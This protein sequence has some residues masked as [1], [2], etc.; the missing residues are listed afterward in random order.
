[1]RLTMYIWFPDKNPQ[2]P[3]CRH[4]TRSSA[5]C[6]SP[7]WKHLRR[8]SFLSSVLYG[9]RITSQASRH[10]ARK[11]KLRCCRFRS[12]PSTMVNYGCVCLLSKEK[13]EKN[14]NYFLWTFIDFRICWRR[15]KKPVAYGTEGEYRTQQP[16]LSLPKGRNSSIEHPASRIQHQATLSRRTGI[17]L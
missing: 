4:N 15:I 6:K 7:F 16:V 10:K 13:R 1:M 3:N 5:T 2:L 9:F 11:R 8:S 14:E 12:V 17:Q